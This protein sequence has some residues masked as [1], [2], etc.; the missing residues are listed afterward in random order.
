MSSIL[1]GHFVAVLPYTLI[2]FLV[3]YL[4][5]TY[6]HLHHIPGPFIAKFTDLWRLINVYQRRPEEV[7]LKL[8]KRY[9]DVI[10]IGPNCVS[11]TG[12]DTIQEIYGIGKGFIKVCSP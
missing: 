11:I 12:P 8:H 1:A 9:G 5:G 6:W 7:Y 10:R 4:F 2:F 3:L